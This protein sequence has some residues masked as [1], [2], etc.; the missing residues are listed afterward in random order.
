MKDKIGSGDYIDPSNNDLS[1]NQTHSVLGW[2][3]A[4]NAMSEF[5]NILNTGNMIEVSK[6]ER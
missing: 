4:V 6:N 2:V 3:N 5:N 1:M